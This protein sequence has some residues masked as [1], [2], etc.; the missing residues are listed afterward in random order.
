MN[1]F[2]SAAR[3]R[4]KAVWGPRGTTAA[5]VAVV[6]AVLLGCAPPALA[7]GHEGRQPRKAT[8]GRPNSNATTY[9]IDGELSRRASN[10]GNALT[11]SK[12][13]V[14]LQPGATLPKELRSFAWRHGHLR[15]INSHVLEVPD[16]LIRRIAQNPSV[17]RLHYDR[18][19]A[20]FNYRTSLAVGTRAIRQ[21]LGLTGAGVGVAVID[22]G[23]AT[24]HDDLTNS[25]ATVYP[26][27]DQRVSA[28]VDFVNGQTSP[29]DDNGHGTH[30][31]GIIAGNGYDSDGQKAGAAPDASLVSLKVLDADGGG[32]VSNLIAALDWVLANHDAYNIRVVNMSVGA[33]VH[34]SAW[35]DPLTLA[36]KRVVDAG[37]VVV[38]AAGNFG[39]N[40]VGLPQYGGISAPGNAPWV[41]TVGGSSTQ[42]TSTRTDDIVGAFSSRGPTYLDWDA[43]PDLVAPGTGT[44]SLLSAGSTYASTRIAAQLPGSMRASSLP[45]LSLTGTSMAAPVV[46]GTVALMLQANPSLTPNAIKAILQYTAQQYPNYDALTQG[47]GFLNAVGALRLARFFANAHAGDVAP[48]Q[49]MWSKHIIWGNHRIGTGFPRV[50]SNA[51]AVTTTWGVDKTDDGDNIVW[52]TA[53]QS[54]DCDNIVWGTDD[55]D[56]IVWGTATD[57]DNIVWGTGDGDNIVWG[58]D[59]GGADCDNIVWGTSDGD[60]IVWGTA[61]DGD[62]IVWG[63]SNADGDNIVWGTSD[64]DNIVWGTDD[65]DNIVWGTDDGDNI[66]WGTNSGDG[67]NIVWGT[68]DG[69]NIVWGTSSGDGDNIVWGTLDGDNIVWG[70]AG[71]LD[72]VWIQSSDGSRS[73]LNGADVFDRLKD[74]TLLQLLEYAPPALAPP[75][76]PADSTVSDAPAPSNPASTDPAPTDVAPT[77]LRQPSPTSSENAPAPT[78]VVPPASTT[79]APPATTQAPP[80]PTT[81]EV[82]PPPA[83]EVPPT[84]PPADVPPPSV[85]PAPPVEGGI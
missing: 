81:T 61:S 40:A 44:V 74:R 9:K 62:N 8:S 34:E 78:A 17:L 47:A 21:T 36:A 56:N 5:L 11:K 10:P 60:N 27:G 54:A 45:Y 37:V 26:F 65:G 13:I 43:K 7:S 16:A 51:Y 50:G 53:C 82:T 83:T 67:D 57:G 30:V 19:A 55:G 77:D 63:T 49:K 29:Y 22:S 73:L 24:W 6:A 3:P 18:P 59:C 38:A 48:V 85:V 42:G 35:T 52:G 79:G 58:T 2:F 76:P 20:K 39:K 15:I 25:T 72:A 31:A 23:I 46:A 12:V 71:S 75:A 68:L 70:T 41:L 69:D 33:A 4:R 1:L 64:G 28:F 14:E 32:T 66:V 80:P 84:P